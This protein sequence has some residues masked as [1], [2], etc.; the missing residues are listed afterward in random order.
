VYSIT[1]LRR[2]PEKSE[3]VFDD[4]DAQ[5]RDGKNEADKAPSAASS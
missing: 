1:L 3:E 5:P 4:P 2:S